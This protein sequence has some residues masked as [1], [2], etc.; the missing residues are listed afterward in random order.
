[1]N[2][3]DCLPI[4]FHLQKHAEG[5]IWSLSHRV[6]ASGLDDEKTIEWLNNVCLTCYTDLQQIFKDTKENSQ[7]K[8][9][10][11]SKNK[12]VIIL[13]ISTFVTLLIMCA[14]PFVS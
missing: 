14:Q 12:V 10:K 9:Q 4:K 7:K 13:L 1:M 6:W 5:Q 3:H 11:E 2:V 8:I